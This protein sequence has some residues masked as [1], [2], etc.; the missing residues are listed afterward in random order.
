MTIATPDKVVTPSAN[1]LKSILD[2][3]IEL[4]RNRL[5]TD[6]DLW[7]YIRIFLGYEIPRVAFCPE[8][9]APFDTIADAFF[10]RFYVG[11]AV[12]HAN[13]GGGKTLNTAILHNCCMVLQPGIELAHVG[14]VERQ[15]QKCYSYFKNFASSKPL[16]TYFAKTLLSD[17]TTTHGSQLQHLPGTYAA[18]SGPHPNI[19]TF[20]EIEECKSWDVIQKSW[21]CPT[22]T[23]NFG[24]FN[25]YT[26]TRDKVG[27]LMDRMLQYAARVGWKV[28]SWCIFDVV[29]RCPESLKCRECPP[30]VQKRCQGRC[31]RTT[32]FYPIRDFIN[33]AATVDDDTWTAQYLCKTPLRT[34]A[35]YKNFDRQVNV[36]KVPLRFNYDRPI[37][38]TIDAGFNAPAVFLWVQHSPTQQFQFIREQRF[39]FHTIDEI[40]DELITMSTR[41]SPGSQNHLPIMRGIHFNCDS[42]AADY[43]AQ[44]RKRLGWVFIGPRKKDEEIDGIKKVKRHLKVRS[45]GIP[46]IIISCDCVGR[47]EENLGLIDEM[48]AF[49]W[50]R[51]IMDRSPTDDTEEK[52]D[53]G[54]DGVRYH[55]EH[56]DKRWQSAGFRS[57]AKGKLGADIIW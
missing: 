33:K 35:V 23:N 1:E 3:F 14:A 6:D 57:Q 10:D 51:P 50:K 18:V 47:D 5:L 12:A 48:E 40:I 54:P 44:L 52:N 55:I 7:E 27:G 46:G 17:A 16:D 20:D 38:I 2:N 42:A 15:G 41:Y 22:S 39:R 37:Y 31:K 36:S 8:H 25:L 43:I 29:A 34:G 24:A 28:Y 21:G 56:F 26:S 11:G 32:G 45:D 9:D 53:H 19:L 13:R 4:G 49:S 30:L